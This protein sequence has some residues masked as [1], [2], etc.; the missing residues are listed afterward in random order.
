MDLFFILSGFILN[1]VYLAKPAD[2]DWSAYLRARVA[3]IMPL[4]YLTLFLM[5]P[6]QFYSVIRHGLAHVGHDYPA[7]LVLN[8][9]LTSGIVGGYHRTFNFPAWS[10]SIEFFCYLAVFPVLFRLNRYFTGKTYGLP[11]SIGLVAIA[12]GCVVAFYGPVNVSIWHWQW[13]SSYVLRGIFGF[14][15]GFLLCSI[16]CNPAAWRPSAAQVNAVVFASIAVFLLVRFGWLPDHAALFVLPCLVFF[17]AQDN[18]IS[19][20][21]L[22]TAPIQWL[23]DRSYSIYL[24]HGLCL[25]GLGFLKFHLPEAAFDVVIMSIILV[26]S[27]LS[28]RFFECPAREFIRKLGRDKNLTGSLT[29]APVG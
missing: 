11:L 17:T 14:S 21:I 26:I 20:A 12:A 8:L 10:I 2:F 13:D 9:S 3:R 23:G 6:L 7:N 4:Y 15:S 28:Y 18:G 16:F 5:L 24:W 19:A 27:E 25:N 1:W 22:K 29:T